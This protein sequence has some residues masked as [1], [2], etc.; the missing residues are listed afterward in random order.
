[1]EQ[2]TVKSLF[3]RDDVKAK[4][5]ELLGKRSSSFITSVLQIVASNSLLSKADPA[6]V[7]QSAAVAAI[8][9]LPLNNNLGFAYIV[10]Y[11]ESYK[12]G[13][14]DKGKDIWKKK[15]V[16]QFQLGY[17]GYKQ[18][19]LR[20]GQFLTIH[21]TDVREGELLKY[22]R[23][24]GEMEFAWIQDNVERTA[25][26]VVGYVSFFKLLN[27]FTQTFYMSLPELM[28]HGKRYSQTFQKDKG[29][30]KDDFHSMALKTVSKLN[31]SK[32]A[33]LSIEMQKAIVFDQAV[34][35]DVDTQDV[36]YVDNHDLLLDKE[37]TLE[38]LTGLYEEKLALLDKSEMDNA[39]RILEAKEEGSYKKLY[40]LLMN[41]AA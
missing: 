34:V 10:P 26:K 12:D 8:L 30:W 7:Y 21:A 16:A 2:L 1:M 6:S 32:N 41:K 22:D 27:G 25:K 20:S 24:S 19:A 11:N 39:K 17:K 9:D 40:E 36:H 18:L 3:N 15:T 29:L 31:L 4:F 23:L 37:V 13:V 5:Q 28:I 33:P 38:E 35:S 14:D